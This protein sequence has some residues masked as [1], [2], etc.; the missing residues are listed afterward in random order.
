MFEQ[1]TAAALFMLL[2]P[3]TNLPPAKPIQ[4]ATPAESLKVLKGFR[5]EL[6]YSVPKEKQGSWVNMCVDPKGRLIVSDQ[7]GPLYRITPPG[8]NGS[9]AET[10][11]E[12]LDVQI[13]EA[14][15]LL[16]AFDHLYVV[17]NKGGKFESGLYRVPYDA[18]EDKFGKVEQLRKI[19]G[20]GEHG[21]HAVLL[22]PD[23]KSLYMVCGNATKIVSPLAA[24]RVPRHWGEDHI[25]KRMPD[26][27]GFMRDTLA[28]G[29][30]IYRVD[31]NG[32][33][34]ELVSN[35]YRN[36]YDMAFNR[37]GELLVYDADMEWDISTPWYRPTRV[38][39][40][41]SGSEF[42]WRNG[43]GK[44]PPYYPDNL[45]AVFNVGPGSPTG[46]CFGYGAKFPAKYQ[47][48]MYLCDWSYG[49]LYALHLTP[50]GSAYKGEI[51][52]FVTGL[53]LPL[54]D[55]V[56]NPFDGAMYFAIGGRRTQSGLYRVTYAGKESTVPAPADDR[57]A[58]LRALRHMLESFHGRQ[59]PKA[60]ET[61][62]DYLNHEDRFIRW[63]ARV[64]L[65]HQD[66]KTWRE[67]ALAET[68]PQAALEALLAL[69]RVSA[70]DPFHR[71]SD[72]PAVDADLKKYIFQALERLEWK[73]LT[74]S[75]Q[76]QLLRVYEV[77]LNRLGKPD[78]SATQRLMTR[79]DAV[80][81]SKSRE[82]NA[83]LC[84]LLVYLE[85][86]SVVAKTLA[87]QEKAATQEEQMEYARSLRVLKNGWTAAQRQQ[88]A[89]WLQKAQGYKGGHSF[90]G[91][92]N[93]M[94]DDTLATLSEKEKT[95][96][97]R[98]QLRVAPTGTVIAAAAKPRPL[99]KNWTLDELAPRVE[100][101]TSKKRDFDRGR[102]LFAEANCFACHRF[103][104]EGGSLG[105]DL[106]G[107]SG[108]FSIRDLLESVVEPS[109]VISD[110]YAAVTI[111]TTDGQVVTGRIMNLN[112]DNI[113]LNTNM[114]DPDAI[115]NVN[116]KRMESMELSKVSMMP[117]NLL[118]TLQEDEICDLMAFLLSRGDRNNKMFK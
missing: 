54:T 8:L 55:A 64:A 97:L 31:P 60:V 41:A 21:P 88:F 5:A 81:P 24:S 34:W 84:A 86:P 47:E 101:G 90:R 118:D 100:Q 111:A 36:P 67:R 44:W 20:G 107:A 71:A 76:T 12:K 46:V 37:H 92:I 58:G 59:D 63:A 48:A 114:L 89:A 98:A 51:E 32:K 106:T 117:A 109:K 65:E 7:Y 112:G 73:K 42:G 57:G 96:L 70:A 4:S 93:I 43:A 17:V 15:G 33:D 102:R 85:A 18:A 79:L 30:C 105:P 19:Q 45:P 103:D 91:F 22:G 66:S 28:P 26:G 53:P 40:V 50:E 1:V 80:Y 116:R 39:L 29:G 82:Q 83:E 49:K 10:K 6:L 2:P 78:S 27:N 25:L 35:G 11:V 94:I 113:M 72:T 68:N 38:C 61:A 13:G 75:Q 108:R 23:G 104:G 74:E 110:Q 9:A 16:W 115:K 99:V 3:L 77:A 95:E 14:Q 52:E 62:G 56:I 69:I 87:L